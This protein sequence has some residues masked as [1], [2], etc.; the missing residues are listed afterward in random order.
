MKKLQILSCP[1]I[2][3]AILTISKYIE[4]NRFSSTAIAGVGYI[5][6]E[7]DGIAIPCPLFRG[8]IRSH[9]TAGHSDSCRRGLNP[10]ERE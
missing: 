2:T 4:L 9:L 10:A 5:N 7:L 6:P 8:K 3:K 1:T